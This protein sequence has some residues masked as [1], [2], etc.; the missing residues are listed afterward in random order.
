[1]VSWAWHRCAML[2]VAGLC[3]A[4]RAHSTAGAAACAGPGRAVAGGVHWGVRG[5]C[6]SGVRARPHRGLHCRDSA[7]R[8]DRRWASGAEE[9]EEERDGRC[10]VGV[11]HPN[12]NCSTI[13][14]NTC[15]RRSR[16][17][18]TPQTVQRSTRTPPAMVLLSLNLSLSH[19][20]PEHWLAPPPRVTSQA[21]LH[22]TG[23]S[24]DLP[25]SRLTVL[26]A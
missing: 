10:C 12:S 24:S 14:C 19:F 26:S 5:G 15:C 25:K 17:H 6:A 9:E 11:H 3:G 23:I 8:G 13:R 20:G 16:C 7:G 1:M 22:L 21:R 2:L 4:G 18:E